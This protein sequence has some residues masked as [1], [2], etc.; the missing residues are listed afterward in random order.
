MNDLR[1]TTDGKVLALKTRRNRV[2]S[3]LDII[4]L[5]HAGQSVV[6]GGSRASRG[7]FL[8][9]VDGFEGGCSLHQVSVESPIP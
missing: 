3:G 8:H 5:E 1:I 2:P 6:E 7:K 4:D 9:A